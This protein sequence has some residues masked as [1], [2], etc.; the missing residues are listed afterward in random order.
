VKRGRPPKFGRA[1]ELVALTLPQDVLEWLRGINADPARAIVSLFDNSAKRRRRRDV[2]RRNTEL[3]SIGRHQSLIVVDEKAITT[4]PG[5]SL[6]P[7][8]AGRSFLALESGKGMADLEVAVL[9]RL[10][11]HSLGESERRI[12]AQLRR[13]LREW[14]HDR[15]L[16]FQ[17]RSII[18]VDRRRQRRRR[19]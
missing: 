4:L 19:G 3:V 18:L 12:L 2:P 15:Q 7:L 14:R 5:I 17:I 6:I 13:Q 1:A 10:E 8:G 16:N 11:A 9:D